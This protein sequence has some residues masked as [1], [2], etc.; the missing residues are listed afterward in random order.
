MTELHCQLPRK[1]AFDLD[2]D[3]QVAWFEDRRP[4]DPF[5]VSNQGA[6]TTFFV[7]DRRF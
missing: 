5:E 4:T 6:G 7:G 1:L 2:D 3:D